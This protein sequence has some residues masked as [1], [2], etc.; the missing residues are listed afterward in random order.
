[1]TSAAAAKPTSRADML[2]I[3][4]LVLLMLANIWLDRKWPDSLAHVLVRYAQTTWFLA[5]FG[6]KIWRGYR[7]RQPYWTGQSWR[8]YLLLTAMPVGVLVAFFALVLAFDA[9]PNLFGSRESAL[10]TIFALFDVALMLVAVA[11]VMR[12]LDWL[13]RG[14]P[15]EQFTRTRWFQRQTAR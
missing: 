5:W 1:M 10:R 14:E 13:E 8:R 12:A 4:G 3:W 11:G 7:R 6:S 9:R 2:A 15:S